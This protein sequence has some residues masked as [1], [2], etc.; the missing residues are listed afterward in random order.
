MAHTE[1]AQD[2]LSG[3]HD[4]EVAG[5]SVVTILGNEGSCMTLADACFVSADRENLPCDNG[6][7]GCFCFD[8]IWQ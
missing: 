8:W 1:A 6:F 5:V 2:V 4:I 7:E 3:M